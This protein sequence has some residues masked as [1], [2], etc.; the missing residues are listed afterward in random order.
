MIILL[1]LSSANFLLI[2]GSDGVGKD[3]KLG[4]KILSENSDKFLCSFQ[5]IFSG[6]SA[7]YYSYKWAE[8][9]SADSFAMFEEN[10][11]KQRE[12]GIKF[13]NT[14]LANGGSKPAMDTFIQFRGRVPSVKPLLRHNKLL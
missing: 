5:H 10:P 11:E 13:K 12:I 7:G 6:Y 14:V 3:V 2:P 1:R 8:V 9:M 4:K